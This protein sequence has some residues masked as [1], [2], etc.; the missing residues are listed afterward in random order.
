[1]AL[2]FA[3][4]T[5]EAPPPLVDLSAEFAQA[6]IEFHDLYTDWA[7]IKNEE[8]KNPGTVSWP[9]KRKWDDEVKP[10]FKKLQKTFHEMDVVIQNE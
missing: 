5:R 9:A 10:A 8:I 3:R 2:M 7:H 6:A 4:T 1:M